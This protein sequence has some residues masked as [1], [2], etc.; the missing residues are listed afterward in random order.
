MAPPCENNA[1]MSMACARDIG[2]RYQ[3][4]SNLDTLGIEH[5]DRR[6]HLRGG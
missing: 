6:H 3:K 4:R 2:N 1:S 5:I